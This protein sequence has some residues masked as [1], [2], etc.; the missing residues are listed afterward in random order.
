MAIDADEV[1][2]IAALAKLDLDPTTVDHFRRQLQA[3]LDFAAMLEEVDVEEVSPTT[4]I[5]VQGQPLRRD[6]TAPCLPQNDALSN[7]PDKA[8]GHFRVPRVLDLP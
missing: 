1:F 3:I 6:D 2:H 7:A 5:R 8:K 4:V